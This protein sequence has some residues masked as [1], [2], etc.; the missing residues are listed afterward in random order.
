MISSLA[1]G[2]DAS[3]KFLPAQGDE[4]PRASRGKAV[5]C[6]RRVAPANLDGLRK[7]LPMASDVPDIGFMAVQKKTPTCVI[8]HRPEGTNFQTS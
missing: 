8:R 1:T 3:R 6:T 4:S 5:K 2:G 7:L